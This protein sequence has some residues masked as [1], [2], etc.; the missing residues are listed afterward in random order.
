M[1]RRAK[2][3]GFDNLGVLKEGYLADM[4]V[5]DFDTPHL[6]P[7]HNAVSNIVYSASGSDVE[8]TVVNGKIVYD[9]NNK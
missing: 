4:I 1:L 8:Y 9:R 2:A 5:L 3:L 7:N 6:S